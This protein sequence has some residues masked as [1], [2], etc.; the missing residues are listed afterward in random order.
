MDHVVTG[1]A[2]RIENIAPL[3][4][5]AFNAHDAAALASLYAESAI[6]MPPNEPAVSG[7]PAIQAWFEEVLSRLRSVRILVTESMIEG[8]QAFQAGTFTS[9]AHA[10][11]ASSSVEEQGA[12][13]AGKYVLFLKKQ[14]GDW[15][16]EYDIWNLDQPAG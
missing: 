16:I 15:K 12:T 2:A 1:R 13:Q 8:D 11:A 6:L 14:A 5:A 7:R 3:M 4:E 9:S 10:D